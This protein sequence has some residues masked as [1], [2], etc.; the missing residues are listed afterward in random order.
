MKAETLDTEPELVQI[1]VMCT[2]REDRSVE[3]AAM[4]EDVEVKHDYNT[5]CSLLFT[6]F[7]KL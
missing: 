6:S 4:L 2:K 3:V 7:M 5:Q 1:F